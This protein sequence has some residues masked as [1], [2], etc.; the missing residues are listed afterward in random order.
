VGAHFG[1]SVGAEDHVFVEERLG[2]Q[3][4]VPLD[5]PVELAASLAWFFEFPE[6][7]DPNVTG[8]GRRAFFTARLR[9][10]GHGSFLSLG[11]GLSAG[12]FKRRDPPDQEIS[13]SETNIVAMFGFE[14]PFK[15]VRP[16]TEFY[17]LGVGGVS[18]LMGLNVR[19]P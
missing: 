4:L 8:R 15:R 3:V 7:S 5:G 19:L 6:V 12:W 1:V 17:F 14:A 13:W 11:G 10:L 18:A 2:I 9:P 16:F